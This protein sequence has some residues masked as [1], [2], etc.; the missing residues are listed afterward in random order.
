M[1][2]NLRFAFILLTL[3]LAALV[4]L[5]RPSLGFREQREVIGTVG[6]FAAGAG[7]CALQQVADLRQFDS[8]SQPGGSGLFTK[9]AASWQ[10]AGQSAAQAPVG[11]GGQAAKASTSDLLAPE[12]TVTDHKMTAG[13][14][15]DNCGTPAAKYNFTPTDVQAYQWLLVSGANVGD[16]VRWEFVQ[17]SGAIYFQT[18]TAPINFSGNACFS[19]SVFIAGRAAASLPG[20]WQTR[21]FYNGA[22]LLTEN[23]TI[24]PAGGPVTVT[25][26]KM[27]GGPI[28][29]NCVA[30][31]AKTI[32]A[33]TDGLAYQWSLLSGIRMGDV[34]RWEFIQPNGSL[35]QAKEFVVNFSGSNGCF[36]SSIAIA[37][38]PPATLPGNWQVR[39]LFNNALLLT[40]NF[41]IGNDACPT[42]TGINPTR[43]AVGSVVTITGTNFTGVSAI[44]FSNNVAA[45][46][47][48]N[49]GTQL[50]VTVPAGA[51]TGPLTI[52]KPNCAD[53]QT[54]VFT[55][56]PQPRIE[57]MPASLA[58][59]NVATGQSRD[60]QLTVRNTGSAPLNIA[61]IT[62][63]DPQ[64]NISLPTTTFALP[65]NGSINI[66]VRFTP[67][68]AGAKTGT[69]SIN[70]N[71]P[72]RP[73]LDVALTG[74][75]VAP[76]IEVIPP[77]LDFGQVRL[78]Q[79]KD[80]VLTIRN[81]GAAP[82]N[83]SSI[84]SNNPQF[85]VTQFVE[86]PSGAL[87]NL[88]LSI[89]P[90]SS[91]E[92]MVRFRPSFVAASVG[93]LTGVLSINSNDPNRPRVDVPL[94]GTGV[95]ALIGAAS[96]LSFGGVTVCLATPTS[97]TL[98]LTNTGNAPLTI[99][100]LAID[101]P[102]FALT[103]Q[104][105]L[106][107]VIAPGASSTLN[108]SFYTRA[109]G[110]QTGRLIISSNAVN[111]PG[112][113][114]A[115]SGVGTPIAPPAI[116]QI[117]VSRTTLSHGRADTARP[118]S[119][120]NPF[121]LASVI[122]FAFPGGP[123]PPNSIAPGA[124]PPALIGFPGLPS[125]IAAAP[126]PL[127]ITLAGGAT[128]PIVVSA[129][130]IPSCFTLAVAE[131]VA[132]PDL[133]RWERIGSRFGAGNLYAAVSIPGTSIVAG[134]ELVTEADFNAYTANSIIYEAPAFGLV[135]APAGQNGG[136][137][138]LQARARRIP[139]DPQ[140]QTGLSAP[141]STSVEYS[142]TVRIEIPSNGV[143]I[144]REGGELAVTVTAQIFG[145][146]D[147][148]INT[149]V[150]W[151]FDGDTFDEVIDD[152]DLTPP[153]APRVLAHTFRVPATE[154]CKLARITVVASSTGNVPFA[155][156]PINPFLEIAPTTIGLFTFRSG[157]CTVEDTKGAL[158]SLADSNCGGGVPRGW[159]QGTVTDASTGQPI[160]GATV[161][162]AGVTV[163]TSD[164]GF[165]VLNDVPVGQQTLTAFADGFAPAQVSVALTA[166]Q[167]LTQNIRLTPQTGALSGFVINALN[168]QSIAGAVV[169]VKGTDISA[170]TG[171]DGFYTLTGV[172]AGAQTV[173]ASAANY[174]AAEATI[175]VP[176]EQ[177]VTQDFFLAP[178]VGV[179]T[180]TVRNATTNQPIA[181]A[182][183]SAGGITTT[184]GGNGAYTLNNV[185]A[186]AQTLSAS[187]DGFNPASLSGTVI[188]GQTVTQDIALA[189]Q[190]G[191]VVG[192]VRDD[193]LQ[194][195]TGA[196]V[197]MGGVT[198][199]TDAAG[200]YTF[201]NVPVGAQTVS[202]SATNYRAATA[203]VT[204][205][206]NQT[207]TQDFTLSRL[208][209]RVQ[210]RV[211][212]A[213]TGQ[214]LANASIDLL[215][216]PLTFATS[217]ASGN[218][219]M[220]DV[221]TGPQVILASAPGYYAKLAVVTVTADQTVT[222]DFA[223]TPQVGTVTG[224]V[225]DNFSQPVV[226]ATLTVAGTNITATTDADGR[227][228]LSDVPVGTQTLNVSATGLRSAQATVNV[229]ANETI[230][231]DIYLQTPTGTVRGTVRNA[232]NNQPIAGASILVGIPFGAVFYSAFTDANGNYVLNDIP[233]G[234]L[235]I[236]A[237][238]DGFTAA[239]ATT[240]VVAN[241]TTTQDFALT[242]EG[243]GATTG[244]ITGVVRNAANNQPVSG[245]VITVAGTNLS[246]TSG[247][248]GSYTL[249]NVPAGAQTL[250]ASKSGFRSA[251]VQVTV[252]AGQTV[253][254][255]IALTPGTGTI[256][257]VAR[258]AATG[259]PLSGVTIT[260]AGTNISATS[261]ADGSF[262]L[263]N[264]PAGAQTLNASANGF[265]AT[266]V[267]VTVTE[268]QT[269][270][271]NISL[272]PVL[273]QGEIR[274]T[275][276]WSKD[277]AGHPDDLDAHL[278]GPNPDGTCFEVA[279]T[280]LGSLTNPPFAQL[281][282]DNIR[283]SGHPPTETVRIAK[284]SPGIYR[285]FVFNYS[286]EDPNGLSQSRATVQIFGSSGQLGN[287]TVPSGTGRYWT[288]FEIN[289]Q[290]GAVTTINQLTT[291]ASNCR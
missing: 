175:I 202:V 165:Y 102:A 180:G 183:V 256:T 205:V 136:T 51:S 234:R 206:A 142:R 33:P 257:G 144:A 70:S 153:G 3:C 84:T 79:T 246:T 174:D 31:A 106:P 80:L 215:P 43:G 134:M 32:F 251:T 157:G 197:T 258:N 116:S 189:P 233:A 18:Q 127:H 64:F 129:A 204:V 277:G 85:S 111:N 47:T 171:G 71:D 39:V 156:P 23:F 96:S 146:F 214:P 169:A 81:T 141:Q 1:P 291:P 217:D 73:R 125:V 178:T 288:V 209:G 103:P 74:T 133:T 235:T 255:D 117:V 159:I 132:A 158:I 227:Y 99:A 90:N 271:Q 285:F 130:N 122:G 287:F 241:A 245:V 194:P 181:G 56:P 66:N 16:V 203:T 17:P 168:G 59:G 60:L 61:S 52:S 131:G 45:Q 40:E 107:L 91:V 8:R 276:N 67:T 48:N 29:D 279:Y 109:T 226:G 231:K 92:V 164:G 83:I 265:I 82:L 6:S 69:L 254:Q 240:T 188:A 143:T 53:V 88:P 219:T 104:P 135:V 38:Q 192:T 95:G 232:A 118:S 264:V 212:N 112:L 172:P 286:G 114:V 221:P 244:T 199:T 27:T 249:S 177:S 196:T 76:A 208:T 151:A 184:S 113:S 126:D 63:S 110:T 218:Y 72:S 248:D 25:D 282:V 4:S 46:I 30:P 11:V 120:F 170:V 253:T 210:G 284:L 278:I 75:G 26:H 124:T 201:N 155:P 34:V 137:A 191:T 105:A 260:V 108:L 2:K 176:A 162:I 229:I 179:I 280:N 58:F 62:S 87:R 7:D 89:A 19:A 173:T 149:T 167:V 42:V 50:T 15:P 283:V 9:P 272:S 290:T 10:L 115:L 198:A 101:N 119:P 211:T 97:A 150:R 243:G 68:T 252:T 152:P 54:A 22:P 12:V 139:S 36:S 222:Q 267:Q 263:S 13:P 24:G 86:R 41:T 228:T 216:F 35:Y 200:S 44:K 236:Y 49:T 37:G 259:Q 207:A 182:T 161:S 239:Q 14:L 238:A 186:G 289:G 270:T 281:E 100:A 121:G 128:N 250:N 195:I 273:Q 163:V 269:V 268:G 193:A 140:C 123:L 213:V 261:G 65:A 225:F 185:P 275:L 98:T 160:V 138:T 220:T 223:L 266:Q 187:A 242:P 93:A 247:A 166:S 28:P 154:E 77:S 57:V 20:A 5:T 274:I 21:V 237:G 94:T 55:V 190:L 230:Y 78:A 262:T 147:P 145:N 224:I 148:A